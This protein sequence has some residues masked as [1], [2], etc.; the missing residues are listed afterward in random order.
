MKERGRRRDEEREREAG[1]LR[2]RD[3]ERGERE[4]IEYSKISEDSIIKRHTI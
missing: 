1:G 2:E 3:G 4:E